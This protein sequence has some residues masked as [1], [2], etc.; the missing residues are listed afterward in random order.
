MIWADSWLYSEAPKLHVEEWVTEK[1][2]TEGKYILIQFWHTF[3]PPSLRMIPHL[4]DWH[5]KYKDELAIICIS[6][7]EVEV[8][9]KSTEQ[10]VKFFSAV[11][12]QNRTHSELH[13]FGLPHVIII[14]PQHGCVIWE[15][16]PLLK[17]Y[18]L[19]EKTIKKI[20]AIGR[21]LKK[22]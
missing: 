12:T 22:Q 3:S 18:E 4:N 7:E 20:L 11:D 1:P 13:V 6:D 5:E 2:E 8:V 15:G 17:G 16:F 9:R 10:H 19:T 14:E 21:K